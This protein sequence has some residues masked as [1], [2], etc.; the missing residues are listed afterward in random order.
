MDVATLLLGG[1]QELEGYAMGWQHTQ[2][3]EGHRHGPPGQWANCFQGLSYFSWHQQ[4]VHEGVQYIMCAGC[5]CVRVR[6]LSFQSG[7]RYR[8]RQLGEGVYVASSAAATLSHMWLC[9]ATWAT[10]SC[11]LQRT[12][13]VVCLQDDS[14][15]VSQM[16]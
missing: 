14:T 5:R 16:F 11:A 2:A 9:R 6:M 7:V 10:T 3:A 12:A 13:Q 1:C 15:A 8:P 4:L